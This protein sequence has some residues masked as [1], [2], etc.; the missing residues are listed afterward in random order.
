MTQER[1]RPRLTPIDRLYME[2]EGVMEVMLIRHGEQESDIATGADFRDPPL[3]ERG[4]AQ[5]AALGESLKDRHID[6]VYASPLQRAL[7]TARAITAHRDDMEPKII[8]DLREHELFRDLPEGSNIGDIMS[9][10]LLR[11]LTSRLINEQSADAYP[12]SEGSAEF[13]KRSVNAVEQAIWSQR[14]Q[15][16]AVVCHAGVINAYVSHVMKS[17]YD[18]VFGPDHTSISVVDALEHRRM[19]RRL[20]DSY[21]LRAG[22]EDLTS[23]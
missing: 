10:E 1:Q 19:V 14:G 20:N 13:R 11:A 9:R 17:P 23:R 22:D 7:D 15:R 5:A 16:I 3:S 21:H 18:F 6:A 2:Q 4:R 12:F 8:D